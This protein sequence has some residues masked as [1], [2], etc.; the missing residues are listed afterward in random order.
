MTVIKWLVLVF[1][2]LA[3]ALAFVARLHTLGGQGVFTLAL[4]ALPG[5]LVALA[6]AFGRPFGR[7]F[8]GLSL[9][10]FLIVAMK[11]SEGDEFSNIM[12]A[13]FGGMVVAL[14][15][16]VKPERSGAAQEVRHG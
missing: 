14:I 8:A 7:L 9:V 15:L 4:A 11:T 3:L 6:V 10:A 1:S 2:L 12:M 16:L 13:A 5:A